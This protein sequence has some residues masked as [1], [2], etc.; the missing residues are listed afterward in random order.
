MN[1][2]PETDHLESNL[3][4]AVHPVLLS[5]CRKLERERAEAMEQLAVWKHE[6]GKL[7]DELK[8][9]DDALEANITT[10]FDLREERDRMKEDLRKAT[11]LWAEGVSIR[12]A[13]GESINLTPE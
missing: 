9:A 3:G 12:I 6:A 8:K 13:D 11:I 10:F 4:N 5:F 1:D 2:T 7:R